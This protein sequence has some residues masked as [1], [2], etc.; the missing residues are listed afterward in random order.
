LPRFFNLLE[1]E[2]HLPEIERLLRTI[3]EL[4]KEHDEADAELSLINQRIALTG[5]MIPPHDEIADCRKRKQ[6]AAAGL[7]E[8]VERIQEI[9]AQIKDVETGLIDFPTLYRGKE[10]YL[11]WKLGEAGISFWHYVEDGFRGRRPID[12]EFLANHRNSEA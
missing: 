8:A 1:A 2:Q 4:K 5:G 12:S 11:C 6:R 3:I 10:V 9:G 7:K